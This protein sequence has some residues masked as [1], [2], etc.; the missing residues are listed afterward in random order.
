M[1]L[2]EQHV[3]KPNSPFF[4]QVDQ[5]AF[6]AKNLYNKANYIIRQSFIH[7]DLYLSY[8]KMAKRLKEAEEF[9]A[10]PRKVSQQVLKSLDKAWQGF[11]ASIKDWKK[12]PH[13]YLGR[14]KLPKYKDKESGRYLLIYTNQ[15]FSKKAL[16]VGL[17]K[18]SGLP[19][20]VEVQ[21]L[22]R[23]KEVNQVRIV[24]RKK[25]YVI[26]IVYTVDQEKL[27]QHH[28]DTEL[29]AGVD[30][31]LNILA[32]IT[33]NK[34]GFRPVVINGRPLKSINQYF[35]KRRANLQSKLPGKRQTSNRIQQLTE[36]R[37]RQVKQ[38]L[39]TAS[40]RI[41]DMLVENGIS[42]LVIGKNDGWKQEINIGKRNN[43][44]FV[45]IPHAQFVEMLTYKAELA[46][47]QV[48]ITEES[49]TSKTSFLDLEPPEKQESYLGRR[50]NRSTFRASDGRLMHADVNG[51]YQIIRKV[52]P[53]AFD[54]GIGG[55]VVHPVG[56]TVK[57]TKA[58]DV[59]FC[60]SH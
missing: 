32:A 58:K 17:I 46:G 18:P 3:I 2:V 16:K 57:P 9:Q 33:S 59:H 45:Q 56:W 11:F 41:I 21:C 7:D 60:S 39:H 31:G 37:N 34:P 55:V 47:I 25:F 38:H 6:A 13:K 53:T 12:N 42:T 8:P 23:A 5:A 44:N 35:N 50:V 19:E 20:L 29:V 1:Q 30:L 24:P 22:D 43:Q 28:L 48:V 26:E 52:I 14:P 15:A 27:P 51:S 10:L 36:K 4:E 54:R 40:R 49:Y